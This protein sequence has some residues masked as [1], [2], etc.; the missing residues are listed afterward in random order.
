MCSSVDCDEQ[1]KKEWDLKAVEKKFHSLLS[2]WL[3]KWSK[4]RWGKELFPCLF[5]IEQA[6]KQQEYSQ[7][8]AVFSVMFWCLFVIEQ[9]KKQQEY[10][11]EGAVFSVMCWC[12]F[13]MSK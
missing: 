10:S 1:V 2:L 3:S 5:V 6:K 11:Q 9:A 12:L 7:E 13:V 8:R 4:G